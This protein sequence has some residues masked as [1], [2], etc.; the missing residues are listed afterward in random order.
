MAVVCTHYGR[1]DIADNLRLDSLVE[2][3][4]SATKSLTVNTASGYELDF[5][6]SSGWGSRE[7][8]PLRAEIARL[9]RPL[10]LHRDRFSRFSRHFA[11]GLPHCATSSGK[12]RAHEPP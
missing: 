12:L 10:L 6:E 9:L 1:P 2:F 4:F 11:S 7:L 8:R 5:F 3:V